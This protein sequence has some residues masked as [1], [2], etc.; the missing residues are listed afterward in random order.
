MTLLLATSQPNFDQH[1]MEKFNT[2]LR[3]DYLEEIDTAIYSNKVD[4]VF[5]SEFIELLS[6][7]QDNKSRY[8]ALLNV[9]KILRRNKIRVIF[10]TSPDSAPWLLGQCISLGVYDLVLTDGNINNNIIENFY[11][12]P[13]TEEQARQLLHSLFKK[14]QPEATNLLVAPTVNSVPEPVEEPISHDEMPPIEHQ[15]MYEGHTPTPHE[16]TDELVEHVENQFISLEEH[17]KEESWEEILPQQPLHQ[18]EE[19]QAKAEVN[20]TQHGFVMKTEEMQPNI[21]FT[22]AVQIDSAPLDESPT[23]NEPQKGDGELNKDRVN[24]HEVK[25][26][27]GVLH[28]P[29][30]PLNTKP[31]PE[32]QSFKPK[33][34]L[35]YK[36]VAFYSPASGMGNRTLSQAY[37][38]LAAERGLN[39]LYVE[40]DYFNPSFGATSGLTHP[41]KNMFQYMERYIEAG[42]DVEIESYIATP[43]EVNPSR[44]ALK[45]SVS[46]VPNNLHFLSFPK[47]FETHLFPDLEDTMVV[48]KFIKHFVKSLNATKYDLIVINLPH[49][50]ENFF[51]IPMMIEVDRIYNVMTLHPARMMKYFQLND[52]LRTMPIPKERFKLLVNQVPLSMR[53]EQVEQILDQPCEEIIPFDENRFNRELDLMIGAPLINEKLG[54]CLTRNGLPEFG[55][56]IKEKKK[57]KLFSM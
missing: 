14:K 42:E 34:E 15:P 26:E 36:M 12:N 25:E 11:N 7:E 33:N 44:K 31:E 49:Q 28:Q 43:A 40:L 2:N 56:P 19:V 20:T 6:G 17:H 50:I 57:L 52:L 13:S 29:T 21:T 47:G 22:T 27:A 24:L 51:V 37:A 18:E 38:M 41:T 48:K 53:K 16:T 3:V 39:V 23:V 35:G 1:I 46:M 4:V 10:L 54:E 5:L 30:R 9:I 8:Q 55:E 45:K 32:F